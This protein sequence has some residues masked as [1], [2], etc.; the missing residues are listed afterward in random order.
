MRWFRVIGSTRF[1]SHPSRVAVV[2][3]MVDRAEG[4]NRLQSLP[5]PFD[6]LGSVGEPQQVL[7]ERRLCTAHLAQLDF[8]DDQFLEDRG[9]IRL[10]SLADQLLDGP[11]AIVAQLAAESIGEVFKQRSEI[12]RLLQRIGDVL[13]GRLH[14]G[15]LA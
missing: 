6:Q 14:G 4:T 3:A 12:K 11:E 9:L 13:V 7:L 15:V 10:W 5:S 2:G 1:E 8:L